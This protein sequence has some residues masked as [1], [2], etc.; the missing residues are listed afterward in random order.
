[1]L[2][3]V[4]LG[5]TI[6]NYLWFLFY[7]FAGIVTSWV[8]I[9]I[10]KNIFIKLTKYTKNKI[11]DII[12]KILS[13]PMPIKL[14]ILIIFV[15]I[16]FRCLET[17]P[18][19]AKIIDKATFIAV[20][21]AITLFLIKFFIGLIEVYLEPKAKKTDSKYDDQVIPVLKSITKIILFTSAFLIVLSNLGYNVTA[22]LAGL[23]IGGIAIAFAAKDILENFISGITIFIEKPFKVGDFLNTSEGLGTVEEIGIRSTKIRTA[24]NTIIV[25]PN[26]LLS[27]NS[28]ENI[29]VRRARRENFLI[30]L[31]YG[32]SEK[33]IQKAQEIIKKTLVD[34]KAVEKDSIIMGFESFGDFSLNIRVI[35]WIKEDD[36]S[37]YI[38]I[39]NKIN[40]TIKKEF[41]KEK[42]EFAYPTQTVNLKK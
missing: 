25:L 5:N 26:R 9:F 29:S 12:A 17:T 30:N 1:M 7:I 4:I 34:N 22:L 13:K 36:Y 38:N 23:G 16:G 20:V 39:K 35:Y 15:N 41:E 6:R 11:D 3:K 31:V 28:V 14:I 32:T 10:I 21:L 18:T 33:K 40:S 37:E 2:E 19:I 8:T 42:I 24:D 27:T